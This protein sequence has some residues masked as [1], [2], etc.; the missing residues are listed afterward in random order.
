MGITLILRLQKNHSI[1]RRL[2]NGLLLGVGSLLIIVGLLLSIVF[3]GYIKNEYDQA[4]LTKARALVALTEQ[5]SDGIEVEP[6]EEVLLEFS[7][8]QQAPEY[9]QMWLADEDT[10][11]ARSQSLAKANLAREDEWNETP[12]FSDLTLPD[13]RSGRLVQI[14]FLPRID[15]DDADPDE[16]VESEGESDEDQEKESAEEVE[17]EELVPQPISLVV[18]RERERL[19]ELLATLNISL[20]AAGG[21]MMILIALLVRYFVKAGLR[22]LADVRSQ[23]A[24]LDADSLAT[25]IQPRQRTEELADMIDQFNG[26]LDRLQNAFERERQFSAD[27]AHELRTPL[28]ELRNLSDVGLRW[29]DDRALVESFFYD[30]LGA[31]SQMERIVVNLLA[32]ARCERGLEVIDQT[33]FD[34]VEVLHNTWQQANSDKVSKRLHFDYSGPAQVMF[35]Y[36]YDQWLLILTNLCNNAVAYS[37]LGAKVTAKIIVQDNQLS[38]SLANRSDNLTEN[39][40]PHLFDRLWRKDLARSNGRHVGLGLTLV[41]AYAEQLNLQIKP[42]LIADNIFSLTLIS[43]DYASSVE[44]TKLVV[45]AT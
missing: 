38:L 44:D 21:V 27:V 35:P 31:T 18:A 41:S 15:S 45:H 43:Y 13:G 39:D 11:L 9:F 20:L 4:L 17:S 23:V 2:S 25:R 26:L 29:P 28:A 42:E 14:D 22:P 7:I 33:A 12:R 30:V 37:L 8:S 6:T 24:Q 36:G 34:L 1:A 40:L 16:E 19:D 5:D 10:V 32:L 3:S